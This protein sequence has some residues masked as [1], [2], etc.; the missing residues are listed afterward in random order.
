MLGEQGFQKMYGQLFEGLKVENG[1]KREYLYHWWV[2]ARRMFFIGCV[3][4]CGDINVLKYML[5]LLYTGIMV[6][7]FNSLMYCIVPVLLNLPLTL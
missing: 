7:T 5:I 2:A 4:C 3:F 6:K 1:P